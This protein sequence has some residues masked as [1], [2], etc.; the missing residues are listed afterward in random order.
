MG[1]YKKM[2]DDELR[3]ELKSLKEEYTKLC[4][5]GLDLDMSRGKP[6]LDQIAI[7]M[8][9]FDVFTSKSEVVS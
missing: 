8:E 1:A 6:G 2:S 4:D 3:E 7:S 9:L 5:S